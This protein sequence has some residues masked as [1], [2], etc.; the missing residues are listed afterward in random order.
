MYTHHRFDHEYPVPGVAVSR[1]VVCAVPRSGSSLLCELLMLSGLAGAPTE[2]FDRTQMD[3][4]MQQ[5]D[6]PDLAGYLQ[7]LQHRK[8]GPNGL[9]GAK[10]HHGQMIDVFGPDGLGAAL[11]DLRAISITREDRVA[12]AVSYSLASQTGRW[13]STHTPDRV[14]PRYRRSEIARL[15]SEIEAQDSGWDRWYERHGVEP[16]R[17]VYEELV[18]DPW[19]HVEQVLAFLGVRSALPSPLP[20]PTLEAQADV[21]SRRWSRRFRSARGATRRGPGDS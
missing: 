3:R 10:L 13:A 5:W 19:G 20:V 2:Y 14:R 16:L 15:L 21:R 4:F 9:F 8:T 1:Y 17:V 6:V 7:Q 12:Q 18:E 11:P